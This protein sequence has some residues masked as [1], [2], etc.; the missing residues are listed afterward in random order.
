[1]STLS[2]KLFVKKSIPHSAWQIGRLL[3]SKFVWCRG[4]VA[5]CLLVG[6]SDAFGQITVAEDVVRIGTINHFAISESSGLTASQQYPGTFWTHNDGGYQFLFAITQ[7]GEMQGAFQI[8]GAN[9]IDWEAIASDNNGNLYLADIGGD[10]IQRTHV[11]VHRVREPRPADSYGN[12]EVTKT[13]LLRFPV[14]KEDCESFFV[15]GEHGYLISRPRT[16]DQVTLYRYP[17]SSSAEST[18]LEEVTKIDVAA[19]AT[20]ASISPDGQRLGVLTSE[21]AHL[22]FINGNPASVSSPTV[23]R[24][25]TRFENSFMEGAAFFSGGFLVS[26][27]TRELWLFTSPNFVCTRPPV[28]TQGLAD[29]TVLLGAAIQLETE[30]DACPLPTFRWRFNGRLLPGQTNASLSLPNV[31]PANV[32]LYEVT[33]S[34]AIGVATSTPNVF[35]RTKSDLHITEVMPSEALDATATT[36]DWWELTNFEPQPVDLA[37]WRFNDSSGDLFDPYD[38]PSGL[39]IAPGE[40]IVF[41][42]GLTATEFRA[43]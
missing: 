32:G 15:H 14:L 2:S 9:L 29:L 39:V 23:Q 40:T 41:V 6:T 10:G 26:A 34:N 31:T 13:W 18:L 16:N 20:D 33:A 35:V 7:S 19:S 36:A 12:V 30:V 38:F 4:A 1:V 27:E 22:F 17:L 3:V 21:G 28:F 42:E 8:V 24:E 11:A 5:V 25:F 43:W 37:G